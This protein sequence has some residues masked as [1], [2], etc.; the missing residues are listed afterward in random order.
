[1]RPL[2]KQTWIILH[3]HSWSLP[4]GRT[5]SASQWFS[6]ETSWFLSFW[7]FQSFVFRSGIV[8]V[9]FFSLNTYHLVWSSWMYKNHIWFF[10]HLH[11]MWQ[12]FKSPPRW[13]SCAIFLRWPILNCWKTQ[14]NRR[15]NK[16]KS[17]AAVQHILHHI[18]LVTKS[19]SG[20]WN[21]DNSPVFSIILHRI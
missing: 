9:S 16:R 15:T 14:K 11:C 2:N 1:M 17:N 3:F 4:I 6:M 21:A 10:F 5:V 12:H 7:V 18:L 19:Q 20:I 8:R 13:K